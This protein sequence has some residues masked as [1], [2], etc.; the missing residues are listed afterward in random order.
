MGNGRPSEF[1]PWTRTL[2][3]MIDR[4]VEVRVLCEL[5]CGFRDLDLIPLADRVGRDYSL[6]GRRCRCRVTAGCTGWNRFYYR[7]GVF[8]PLWR[9]EDV[10]RWSTQRLAE[11]RGR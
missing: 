6:I 9:S 3:A 5:L 11:M 2:G 10:L 1:P 8:R 7:L 4:G